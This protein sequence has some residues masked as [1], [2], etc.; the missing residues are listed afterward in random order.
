MSLPIVPRNLKQPARYRTSTG[1][2]RLKA[3]SKVQMATNVPV[4]SKNLSRIAS[5]V[6]ATMY[7]KKRSRDAC[8]GLYNIDVKAPYIARK[9]ITTDVTKRAMTCEAP[10]PRLNLPT[11]LGRN[12]LVGLYGAKGNC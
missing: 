3:S 1:V 9:G 7:P 10:R 4:G 8:A 6:N 2:D 5:S 11:L 12:Q